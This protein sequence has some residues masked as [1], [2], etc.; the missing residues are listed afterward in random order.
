MRALEINM[1][2]Y[3]SAIVDT[4]EILSVL[5]VAQAA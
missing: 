4:S 3:A 1:P 5:S 2:S